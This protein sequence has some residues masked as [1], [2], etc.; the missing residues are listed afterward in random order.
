MLF[1]L[2]GGGMGAGA[3]GFSYGYLHFLWCNQLVLISVP[4]DMI[5]D[6]FFLAE[7]AKTYSIGR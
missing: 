3:T 4:L 2:G 5:T 7:P 6:V 1:F